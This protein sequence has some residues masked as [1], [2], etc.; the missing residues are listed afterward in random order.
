MQDAIS[1]GI[2]VLFFWGTWQLVK[3]MGAPER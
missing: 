1:L 3:R 2:G